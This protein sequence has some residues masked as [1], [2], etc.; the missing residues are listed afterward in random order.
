MLQTCKSLKVVGLKSLTLLSQDFVPIVVSVVPVPVV[1]PEGSV[2]VLEGAVLHII[3][4]TKTFVQYYQQDH[5]INSDAVEC[6]DRKVAHQAVQARQHH[7]PV[8]GN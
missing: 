8:G 5:E 4:V 2:R 7:D 3:T 6:G 1:A